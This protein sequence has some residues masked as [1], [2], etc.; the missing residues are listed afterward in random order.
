MPGLL[1]LFGAGLKFLALY[2]VTRILIALGLSYIVISGFDDMGQYFE[3][4]I[5]S[6]YGALPAAVYEIVSMA[7]VDVAIT[8]LLSCISVRMI[9]N[10]VTNGIIGTLAFKGITNNVT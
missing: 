6:Q 3:D 4:E 7:G 2:A 5:I 9:M 8:I 10:G 1:L